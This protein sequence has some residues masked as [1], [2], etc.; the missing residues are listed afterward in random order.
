MNQ[1][2]M[3]LPQRSLRE[4]HYLRT[5]ATAEFA[6]GFYDEERVGSDVFRWMGLSGVL[7]FGPE[8]VTRYLEAW[9]FS[10]FH[11]LSHELTCEAGDARITLPLAQGWA[12]ISVPIAAGAS[13][14]A[15]RVNKIFPRAY[16]S[17]TDS[18][19]LAIR[20][21]PPL[22]HR[23]AT[24]H[25]HIERQHAN[26]V[27]N[28]REMLERQAVLAS[29]PI[30]V[31]IDLYGVCNVKPPCVYCEWDGAK[32]LEGRHVDT[33]FTLGTLQEWG[34]FF[35]NSVNL[36]NCS[37]GEPFMMK[38][39]DDLLDA[40]GDAGK[41]LEMTTNGQIL[42][43][44][45]IQRLL[46]R[47]ID[48]YVS[49]D[50][51]TRQTYARLRNDRFEAILHNLRR[52]I[53]AKGGPG[54]LPRVHLVFMPMRANV[55]E[56]DAFVRLCADL[57]ADRLV[58]RPLNYTDSSLQ[59]TRAGYDFE[60]RK[61]LLPFDELVRVSGRVAE[62][63]RRSGVELADQMDFG[64]SMGEQF[65][66]WFEEGGASV[67]DP[68]AQVPFPPDVSSEAKQDIEISTGPA[69]TSS[70]LPTDT[71]EEP[72]PSLGGERRPICTEPWKS[73]YILRRGVFPC[74][75]GA[76]PLAE[77]D[78]YRETWNSSELQQIRAE[79]AQD[80][81]PS[82]CLESSSCP[83][84]RKAQAAAP[85]VPE[86][87]AEFPPIPE[88]LSELPHT[89]NAPVG[90]LERVHDTV[91]WITTRARRA[92][93]DPTYVARHLRRLVQTSLKSR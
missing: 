74:C 4:R 89:N 2:Q 62:L 53:A 15:L 78:G 35:D 10:E 91:R 38:N 24:R 47:E 7:T 44:R 8:P 40:F 37:I 51:A 48:L 33:P 19:T 84:V 34:P 88:T 6:E 90:V 1:L 16:Y 72:L 63:C 76:R 73:L 54:R 56:V 39:F 17:A 21:R 20:L 77:M 59:W 81:F 52:L 49:L 29:T 32:A 92:V 14:V 45:N 11:D 75:Y 42:T 86:P 64:G 57:R 93:T 82:Y 28:T 41:V 9:V 18:R 27:R 3:V 79:L 12:P 30:T 5:A 55:G 80:R 25:A 68:T 87:R 61:E 50:A 83:I 85:P 65:N 36:V 58:L 43:D 13:R 66:I 60:Y 67:S 22:L 46:D 23:D 71:L 69:E 70:P 26:T 31:G